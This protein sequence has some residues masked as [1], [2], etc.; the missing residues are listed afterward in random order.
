MPVI[1]SF[2]TTFDSSILNGPTIS[3]F[4]ALLDN[5][6]ATEGNKESFPSSENNEITAFL[7]AIFSTTVM[8]KTVTY[9]IN[10]GKVTFI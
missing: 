6:I 9:L 2:F 4:Y 1:H 8:Q 3:K 10:E 5:Y 7:D